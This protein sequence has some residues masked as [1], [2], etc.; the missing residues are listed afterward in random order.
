MKPKS[1]SVAKNIM[2]R[3]LND[4]V[5]PLPN[6]RKQRELRAYF[7]H[8]CCY[9]GAAAPPGH[10]H[11]DH[12]SPEGGNGLGN[13]VLACSP[14]NGN[15]KR[16]M[17]WEEFLRLKC[18]DPSEHDE[19][20]TRIR[21]WIERHRCDARANEPEVEAARAAAERAIHAFEAAYNDL[22]SALAACRLRPDVVARDVDEPRQ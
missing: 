20:H 22:R 15:E 21:T 5:D 7:E 1:I 3:A 6:E 14:C 16:D 17:G 10:G 9:C 12:A 18:S 19:R 8:R 2:R 11:F 4:L 13:L